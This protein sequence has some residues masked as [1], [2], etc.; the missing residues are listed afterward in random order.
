MVALRLFLGVE[1]VEVSEKLIKTVESRQ[2]FVLVA[3]VVL[4]KLSTGVAMGFEEGGK[5][6]ALL[7]DTVG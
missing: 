2:V 4:A 6:H 7:T 3:Q 1:V 5:C